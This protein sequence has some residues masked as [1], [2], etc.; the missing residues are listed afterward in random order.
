[1]SVALYEFPLCEK[2]RNYLR[3]EQLLAQLKETQ[4]ANTDNEYLYFFNVFFSV[5]DLVD[6]LDLRTDFLR[7]I[8]YHE[9]KFLYW[10][11][12]PN[13]DH[14]ALEVALYNLQKITTAIKTNKNLGVSLANERFLSNIRHRFATPGGATCFDLP[15]LFCWLKQD[16]DTKQTTM[17]KWLTQ[18]KVIQNSIEMIMS[19]LREKSRYEQ[20]VSTS[21]FHQGS[22]E[23]KVELLRIKCDNTKGVYPVVSGSRN[24]Y[25]IKFM[26]LDPHLGTSD[27]VVTTVKFQLSCC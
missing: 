21:G 12:H 4:N 26:Q 9:R 18:F 11:K 22:V 23:D 8:D 13:I 16:N 7:D 5:V 2:V 17:T 6:R 3:L 20:V 27:A 19:L 10:S 24:R 15:S 1:M 25:G 14:D